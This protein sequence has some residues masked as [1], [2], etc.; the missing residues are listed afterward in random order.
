LVIFE[1]RKVRLADMLPSLIVAP[2]ITWFWLV[3]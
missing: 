3:R 1:F 2:L